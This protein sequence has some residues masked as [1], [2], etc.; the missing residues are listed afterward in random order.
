MQLKFP[1][2]CNCLM[3]C[4]LRISNNLAA[5]NNHNNLISD[6]MGSDLLQQLCEPPDIMCCGN[7][8]SLKMVQSMLKAPRGRKKVLFRTG[9]N[10]SG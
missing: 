9:F 8:V 1:F 3:S 10:A 6:I 5:V 2:V 4:F 7:F